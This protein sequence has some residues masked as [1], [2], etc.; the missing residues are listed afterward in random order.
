LIAPFSPWA[1]RRRPTRSWVSFLEIGIHHV[2]THAAAIGQRGYQRTKGLGCATSTA[3]H[4][5]EVIGVHTHLK[6]LTARGALRDNMNVVW[7]VNDA[8]NQML[9]SRSEQC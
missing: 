6:N 4:T 3:N 2:Y 7:L 1:F 5:T 8:L 9:E